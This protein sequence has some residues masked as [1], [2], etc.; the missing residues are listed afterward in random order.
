MIAEEIQDNAKRPM[1]CIGCCFW[2][3][4]MILKSCLQYLSKFVVVMSAVSGFSFSN[5]AEASFQLMKTCFVDGYI[6]NRVAVNTLRGMSTLLSGIILIGCWALVDAQVYT[7]A[8]AKEP[9][10]DFQE[11]MGSTFFFNAYWMMILSVMFF[12]FLMVYKLAG[13]LIMCFWAQWLVKVWGPGPIFGVFM[14]IIAGYI[15]T[16]MVDLMINLMEA[17]FVFYAIDKSNGSTCKATKEISGFLAEMEDYVRLDEM[18]TVSTTTTTI[19]TIPYTQNAPAVAQAYV[20]QPGVAVAVAQ[21]VVAQ[22]YVAQPA[23]AV[24]QPYMNQPVAVAQALPPAYQGQPAQ[25][26]EYAQPTAPADKGVSM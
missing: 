21:P 15:F 8:D 5:S 4:A 12:V 11:R 22:A 20:A 25:G 14:G 26:Q 18:Q 1:T 7:G 13:M 2:I 19:T 16:Y 24:A 3:M 6:S 17:T 23:V 10:Q 9:F